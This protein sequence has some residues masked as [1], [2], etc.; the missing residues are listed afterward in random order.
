MTVQASA[1]TDSAAHGP[2]HP[3]FLS[4]YYA[5]N[6]DYGVSA[7]AMSTMVES[8]SAIMD[9]LSI[10]ISVIA[11]ISLLVGGIG[12]MN[13][14][15]VSV[16]E[17]TREIGI[18]KA[19]GA[20]NNNIR[21]QFVVESVIVCLIGGVIGILPWAPVLGYVG[22]SSSAR[23]ASPGPAISPW[24]WASPWPSASS[25]ATTPANKAAR[26]DPIEALRYE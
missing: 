11:G 2:E 23:P 4:R 26:L 8:M 9:T 6:E 14:M 24:P 21:I 7:M 12:V 22:S 13:I 1:G 19:L 20:T 16:T 15:L 10:A 25:S 18:R 17:R 3:E 5:N